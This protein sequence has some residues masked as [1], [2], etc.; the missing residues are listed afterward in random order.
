VSHWQIGDV[1][2]TKFVEKDFPG[3]VR[4]FHI[5]GA[6]PEIVPPKTTCL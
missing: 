6:K 3:S 1:H 5:A 4:R 2:I